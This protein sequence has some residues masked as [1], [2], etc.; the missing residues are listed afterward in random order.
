MTPAAVR[1]QEPGPLRVCRTLEYL[2]SLNGC[3]GSC[4]QNHGLI[5][6]RLLRSKM[7]QGHNRR[8]ALEA[9]CAGAVLPDTLTTKPKVACSLGDTDTVAQNCMV[10]S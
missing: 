4:I 7:R 9:E 1:T 6:T 3:K 5:P 8:C 10:I 2:H